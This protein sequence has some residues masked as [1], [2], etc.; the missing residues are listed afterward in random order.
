MFDTTKPGWYRISA[1]AANVPGETLGNTPDNSMTMTHFVHVVPP[2]DV[3]QD[4]STTANDVSQIKYAYGAQPCSVHPENPICYLYSPY[5]DI[6]G[7]GT[8]DAVAIS[9]AIAHYG[10]FT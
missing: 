9:V 3:D 5:F 10:I 8:V 4:G 7:S 1:V 6:S 2:G